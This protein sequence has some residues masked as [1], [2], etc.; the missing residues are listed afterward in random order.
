MCSETIQ[1]VGC[2]T[3]HSLP[4]VTQRNEFIKD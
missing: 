3:E 1:S 2:V 4:Q